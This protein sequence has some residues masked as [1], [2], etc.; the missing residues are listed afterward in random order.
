MTSFS[1]F[2]PYNAELCFVKNMETKEFQFEI[3]LNVSL[4]HLN[5]YL[6]GGRL[7]EIFLLLQRGDRL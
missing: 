4:I 2:N 7:L 5:T 6:Y 1:I 3:I